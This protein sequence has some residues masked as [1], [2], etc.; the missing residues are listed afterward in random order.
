MS[1]RRIL[2]ALA[3]T[4]LALLLAAA[5][6][7]GLAWRWW[8]AGEPTGETVTLRIPA[9]AGSGTVADSLLAHGLLE[10]R[11]PFL[12]GLRWSGR[13]ARLQAGRFQ[14]PLGAS[15]RDLAV[16]LTEGRTLPVVLTLIEGERLDQAAVRVAEVYHAD[17]AA[18]AAAA[19]RLAAE[20]MAR[21]GWLPAGTDVAGLRA[22]LQAESAAR[23][24]SFALGEGY[25]MPQT[26]HLSEGAGVERVVATV[27]GA[28]LDT[29]RTILEGGRPD[30]RSA[31]L[32]PHQVLVLASIV[33]AETPV[34]SEMPRVAA[35]YLNRL[36]RGHPLEADPTVAFAL[37]KRGRRIYFKDLK[38][39]SPFN[40]Y[41]SKGLPPTPIGCPGAAAVRAVLR[42]DPDPD[43]F[44]FVADGRGGHVFSRT[45]E[46]HERAVAEYRRRRGS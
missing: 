34:R 8:N 27:M 9:G 37:D 46:E 18:V 36:A 21:E 30:P 5:L 19:D 31:T 13:D 43:V 23:G 7:A 12:L 22:A 16:R 32:T 26:Y 29:L 14:L 10:H 33:E 4:A 17:P 40:T 42:P 45:W 11:R 2:R 39:P 35:V 3:V 44:Y 38:V 15:P 20:V 41:L 24:R 28:G 6:T 1:A 25:L